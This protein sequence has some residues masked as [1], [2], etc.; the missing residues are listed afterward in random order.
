M[1][2]FDNNFIVTNLDQV[3]LLSQKKNEIEIK[4]NN[5]D[6]AIFFT[7]VLRTFHISKSVDGIIT[8]LHSPDCV[9]QPFLYGAIAFSEVKRFLLPTIFLIWFKIF[10]SVTV[11]PYHKIANTL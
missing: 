9:L 7:R 11:L 10:F 6:K 5:P 8:P 1:Y 2:E 4:I 3:V